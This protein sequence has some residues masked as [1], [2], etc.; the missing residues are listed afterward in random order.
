M[1]L[2]GVSVAKA[3]TS[4]ELAIDGGPRAYADKWP[5]RHLLGDEEK[6]AV[7]GLLDRCIETGEVLGYNGPE[8][9][10]LCREFAAYLGGG[11][12]D[13]VNSGSNALYVALRALELE[14]FSEVV[15][16]PITDPGGVMPV[17]L[18]NCVPIPA[19]SAPGSYN[20]DAE[21]I[22]RCLSERTG[23]IIVAHIAGI[24]VDMDPI[25]ELARKRSLPVI[26]DCAQAHGAVYKERRV[27]A[28]G[29]VAVFSTMSGKHF[30]TGGQGGLV[31]TRREALYWK[32]RQM[33][34]RGKPFGLDGAGGNV[35][36]A[37][38][39]NMDELHAAMGRVQL[40]KLPSTVDR[41]RR[42]AAELEAGCFERLAS[43][44]LVADPPF[45]ESS[46]WFLFFRFE[47]ERL[48]VD[49]TQFVRALAAE[50]LPVE[51]SYLYCPPR[52]SWFRQ[53]SVYGT[54]QLPWS[55]P[56]Y[57]GDVERR[58]PMTNV[59]T[60]D[61]H[62]FRMGFHENL[63]EREVGASLLAL[64]KVERAYLR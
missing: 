31:F 61:A 14:P 54:S 60:T 27:G 19:D 45:G 15:V 24:P 56:Q 41:R 46:Y 57:E 32:V 6:Q 52:W 7:V 59:T 10:A 42:L 64:E 9:E 26:E 23:A 35:V 38:N 3:S 50:G 36:A 58:Y 28:F 21:G 4:A 48:R 39:C 51:P 8:E 2:R 47:P 11:F 18:I 53:R 63:T 22:E 44:R 33:A 30:S 13:G 20:T 25:L 17:P 12:A 62:H 1:S 37:L 43:V 49:K 40:R 16:P 55:S 29:D 34:D 5:P